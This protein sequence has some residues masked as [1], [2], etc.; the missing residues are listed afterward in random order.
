MN[1]LRVIVIF[2]V[3]MLSGLGVGSAGLLVT[4]LALVEHLPQTAAQ[5]LNL[6]FFLFSSTAA[7]VVHSKRTPPLWQLLPLLLP[8][9]IL[10]SLLGARLA[11]ALPQTLLR[12]IFGVFLVLVGAMGL[13]SRKGK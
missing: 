5:G 9:G 12:Q 10:G 13:F 7:L 11:F 1:W 2:L 3:A 6:L 8:T 4:W